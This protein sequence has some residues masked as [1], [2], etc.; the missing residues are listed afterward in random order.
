M[1]TRAEQEKV[2]NIIPVDYVGKSV[3]IKVAISLIELTDVKWPM[4]RTPQS[5]K[6]DILEYLKILFGFQESELVFYV[7]MMNVIIYIYIIYAF[8]IQGDNVRNQRENLVMLLADYHTRLTASKPLDKLQL[9][10]RAVDAV[11]KKL[12]KNYKDWCKFLGIDHN[13]RF[14]GRKILYIGLYLLIWG[15]AANI[16]FMPECL[17]YIFH[18]MAFELNDTLARKDS[19]TGIKDDDHFLRTII[20]PIYNVVREEAHRNANGKASHSDWSNYDDLNEYFWSPDCLSLEWPMRNDG[21]FF[22]STPQGEKRSFRKKNFIETRSFW[23]I[24]HSFDRFWTFYILALQAIIILAFK[25]VELREILRGD[26]LSSLSSIF[27]TASFLLVLQSLL[28]LTLNFPGFHR[29]KF[30]DLLRNILKIIFSTLWCLL[31]TICY[32]QSASNHPGKLQQC[33]SFLPQVK[34]IPSLSSMI[35]IYLIPNMLEAIMFSFPMI[36]SRIEI[37]DRR[38]Y[39]LLLWW[40]Q[41]RIYVGRGMHESLI[42]RI[43]YT[44]FWLILFCFKFSFNYFV[45]MKPLVK[46]THTIIGP[47]FYQDGTHNYGA[48]VSLW[49]PVIMVYFFDTQIWYA[50]FS[51]ICGGFIGAFG[52]LGEIRTLEMLS[53]RFRS[54][55]GAFNTYLVHSDKTRK[56]GFSLSKR[57]EEVTAPTRTVVAKFYLLWNEI[58]SSFREEDLISDW[59]KDLLLVPCKP[60]PKLKLEIQWPLFLLARKIPIALDMAAQFQEGDSDLWNRICTDDYMRCAV[61][62]CYQSFKHVL[63]T[64]LTGENRR[65]VANI[66]KNVDNNINILRGHKVI[67]HLPALCGKFVELVEILKGACLDEET[68]VVRL[69]Q[70]LLNIVT[71]DMMQENSEEEKTR[72]QPLAADSSINFPPQKTPQWEEQINRL[73]LL[74]TVKES[75]MDVPRNLEARRRIAFF[76]NSLF[77]DMPRAPC[78]R[79]MFSFSVLTPYYS[80]ETVYSQN[81]LEKENEDGISVLYYL[82]KNFPDEWTNFLERLS[83][84][85]E[86]AVL[87]SSAKHILQLRHWVSLRGQ[88]LFRTVRGMMYYRRALKLQAFL[89]MAT[90]TEIEAGITAISED[91]KSLL[92][93]VVDRKFTYVVTCQNYGNQKRNGDKEADDIHD[94]MI[95][96]P[97][98]RVAYIDDIKERE[99]GKLFYSVLIKAV[100]NTEQEIYRIRLPGPAKIGEG[101]PENQNHALI[102]T[103]GETLQ[104]IDMNQDHYLEEAFKIRNLLQEFNEDH[105]VRAPTILGL[106]EHIFTGSVS[107]LGWFM[108]NQE[109][110]F[111]T[112]GQR[113]F[114]SPLK[115]RFHYGHPDVFDKIFHITRGGI[116]KASCGINLSEDIFGGFNSTLRR[117]NITHHEYIQVGKG[118]DVGLNQISLFE[119]KVA[120]G[121][122]EQTLSR[123]LYR[124]GH[125]FDFFRMMSCYITTIGFYINSMIIVL[126]VYAF[127]YSKLYLLW[128]G[129]EEAVIFSCDKATLREILE[130]LPQDYLKYILTM[131]ELNSS[132]MAV[133]ASQSVVQLGLL[134]AVPILVETGLERGFRTALCEFIIMQ[135]QLA[136]VFFTF[137]LGTKVHHYGRTLL[138]GGAKYR[139]TG[140]GFVVK[141][142]TF[143]EN[144]R[145]YSRSHF[146]KAMEIVVLLICYWLYGKGSNSVAYTFLTGS[147]WFLVISWL[148][149][150]FIFNP[151]GF[152]WQKTLDD[153]NDW[154]TWISNRAA[155]RKWETWWEEEQQ[156]LHHSAFLG[157]FFEIVLSFRYFIFQFFIIHKLEISKASGLGEKL[158]YGLSWFMILAFVFILQLLSAGRERYGADFQLMYRLTKMTLFVLM[159]AMVVLLGQFCN[160][161]LSDIIVLPLVFLPTG[162]ALLQIS[163]V[164]RPLMK[165]LGLWELVKMFARFYDCLMGLVIFFPLI[166]CSWFPSVSEFQT[167]LLFNQAFSRGLH[168][169][170]ILAGG[171]K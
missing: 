7:F 126:T 106:R 138:H 128:S 145:T 16:R 112:I 10:E 35:V 124:L 123:D 73:H 54:L 6:P 25:Q 71:R 130:K 59:E 157:K 1:E 56:R 96:N 81:D 99:G 132:L 84:K 164:G 131:C 116:S 23:H 93:E 135:I 38:I 144:Y 8:H 14:T 146:V 147:I 49:L 9:N 122:G 149:A 152:E 120:C 58:I 103:R 44:L 83:C 50:L 78:V 141:H 100:G 87:K 32:A 82:Q 91:M 166:V 47:G 108:S 26:V 140:R 45:Q 66:I 39:R 61:V 154:F 95:D 168:I 65:T 11:M 22:K 142:A 3:E 5:N 121:S 48:V 136:S 67:A 76:T 88:T 98:L 21:D 51:S 127:L 77:M 53:S 104:A 37:S 155:D 70:D 69:L 160:L 40:S 85:D 170:R 156:H 133:M 74:L 30:P 111:V 43:K 117:G 18:N 89:D 46:A 63:K 31:L 171:K 86:K 42:T 72:R 139:A 165:A 57:S 29:W 105:G 102:F 15:E 13:L 150:P 28:D 110:S 62:E 101:K 163:Q 114:A 153:W 94:L 118:R 64:L 113:V 60:D 143:A 148:F 107:S 167:R 129:M 12:F 19:V 119:A 90:E 92:E 24:Y 20:E 115:V 169:S 79:N 33:L 134:L 55:P 75:A 80:E 34:W 27:I 41:P 68:P 17:N 162:W 4:A 52:R 159:V 36:Q 2:Y 161:A 125:S 158:V 151:S 137:S 97:S 109:T